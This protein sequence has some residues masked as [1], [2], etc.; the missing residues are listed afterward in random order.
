M[1]GRMGHFYTARSVLVSVTGLVLVL[2]SL[3]AQ[4]VQ[5]ADWRRIGN[6]AVE[7]SL[8]GPASG[9]VDR[10][11]FDAGGNKI[12]ARTVSGAIFSTE[13]LEGWLPSTQIAPPA[14]ENVSARRMP[15]GARLTRS[16][17]N[18][19]AKKFAGGAHIWRTE[20][21][22]EF[23][24]NVTAYKGRS[25]L[26]GDV[27][28]LAVSPNDEDEIVAGTQ[29][30]VWRS[31]DGGKSWLSLNA[32]LPNLSL[33]RIL[34]TPSGTNGLRV[35]LDG[36][37]SGLPVEWR[38]G[39]KVSWHPSILGD[40]A[41]IEE[42][43]QIKTAAASLRATVTA[44]FASGNYL[45]AGTKD[46][47]LFVSSNGGADWLPPQATGAGPVESIRLD[48]REPRR[49]IAVLSA[50]E[51]QTKGAVWRTWTAGM[52]W[53]D[54]TGN[55]NATEIKGAALDSSSGAV[56]LATNNG[57]FFAYADLAGS[58][59]LVT[60]KEWTKLGGN[61]P[62]SRVR[63]LKLDAA[64]NQLFVAVEGWGA[65]ATMAP[66]RFRQL[67]IVSAADGIARPA[68]PG[69]LISVLGMKV[70]LARVGAFASPILDRSA[71]ESQ[72]QLPFELTGSSIQL[73]L[74]T[75]RGNTQ[76]GMPLEPT[77]PAIFVDRD[78]TPMLLNA[79]SGV[80]L[81][82]MQPARAGSR[83][84]ILAAGLGRVTPDWPAGLAA[85][86]DSPPKV[87]SPV[88]VLLDRIP[89][90]VTKATLAP[91]FVGFYLIE[92]RLPD[93]INA[94]PAELYLETGRTESN[95]VRIY[96]EQ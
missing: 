25:I 32:G 10:V 37:V 23:W 51:G 75:A 81:D 9:A 61:L 38:P 39:E 8:S 46:G 91:S 20:T 93:V 92:I 84:Q 26:G 53:D 22:G 11:W 48:P 96:L 83:I 88:R 67:R 65:F 71:L 64:S 35:E 3:S 72:I 90:E 4:S 1:I 29:S 68:A 59:A 19:S 50:R 56:Y 41:A 70:D 31:V 85:P 27:L 33:R 24:E 82:V 55:L 40:T 45:Y 79:D 69:S 73:S 86:F 5:L 52:F 18:S 16:R 21:N 76:L 62:S 60:G 78:G 34:T 12:F 57:V 87:I 89:V 66:H 17:F 28:D 58:E 42:M 74:Q 80:L 54:M 77:A 44:V 36:L 30:G 14:A 15:D 63:D 2:G 49:A 43:A 95:R 47:R 13:D 6:S 94:G 7:L